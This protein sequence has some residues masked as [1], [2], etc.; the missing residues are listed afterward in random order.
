MYIFSYTRS[1]CLNV[2]N[3]YSDKHNLVGSAVTEIL[4]FRWTDR[5]TNLSHHSTLSQKDYLP[6]KFYHICLFS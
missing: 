4:S 1:L 3:W 2:E 5:H 6:M